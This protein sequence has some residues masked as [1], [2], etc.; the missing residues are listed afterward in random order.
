METHPLRSLV[1]SKLQ[2]WNIHVCTTD[3][4]SVYS[5]MDTFMI[6]LKPITINY[7]CFR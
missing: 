5:N 1:V 4:I 6:Q 7:L 2:K 3:L